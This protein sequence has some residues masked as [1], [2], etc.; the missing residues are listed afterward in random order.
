MTNGDHDTS[1]TCMVCDP[2][3]LIYNAYSDHIDL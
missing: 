1:N 3:E 2:I